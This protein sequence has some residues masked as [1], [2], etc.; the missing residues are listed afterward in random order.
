[1]LGSLRTG[2]GLSG[3]SNNALNRA[4]HRCKFW[5][6]SFP[7]NDSKDLKNRVVSHSPV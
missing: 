2:E 1:M 4:L 3:K 5:K 7:K 6:A